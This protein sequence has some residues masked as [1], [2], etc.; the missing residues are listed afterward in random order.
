[1]LQELLELVL[2]LINFFVDDLV[3]LME[4]LELHGLH[5]LLVTIISSLGDDAGIV[6]GSTTVPG[7]DLEQKLA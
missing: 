5:S 7:K 4:S 3:D 2:D 6:L 1:M